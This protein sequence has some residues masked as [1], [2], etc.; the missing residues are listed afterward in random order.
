MNK[1]LWQTLKVAPAVVTASL[2][3]TANG[4]FAQTLPANESSDS[5]GETLQQIDSYQKTPT[6]Q[7]RR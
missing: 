4:V 7:C 2:L 5:V 6:L 1:L 3:T